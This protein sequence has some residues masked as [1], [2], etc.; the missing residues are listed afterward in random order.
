MAT[1][2][3]S[4]GWIPRWMDPH[5]NEGLFT[6]IYHYG[7]VYWNE[8]LK[9]SSVVPNFFGQTTEDR[10]CYSSDYIVNESIPIVTCISSGIELTVRR[11]NTWEA[12]LFEKIDKVF[13]T[14]GFRLFFRNLDL[15]TASVTADAS[16]YLN[17]PYDLDSD[18]AIILKDQYNDLIEVSQE[19]PYWD[20]RYLTSYPGDVYTA[21]FRTTPRINRLLSGEDYIKVGTETVKLAYYTL[22]NSWDRLASVNGIKRNTRETNKSI[23]SRIQNYILSSNELCRISAE[24]G[25]SI[26]FRWNTGSSFSFVG[27]GVTAI[28]LFDLPKKKYVD[29]QVINQQYITSSAD[30]LE[31]FSRGTVID[32]S[33]F[34]TASGIINISGYE[35]LDAKYIHNNYTFASSALTA[36]DLLQAVVFGTAATKVKFNSSSRTKFSWKWNRQL[37]GLS[38]LAEFDF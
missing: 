4:V 20:G 38:G 15:E 3:I 13:Y 5:Y 8:E 31:L 19:N 34:S 30:Y 32:P 6:K 7:L 21:Y 22:E 33:E 37:R 1:R 10:F 26:S 16:G 23:K 17:F 29:E 35:S 25:A 27:S 2:N 12:F 36:F 14:D 24:L 9:R 11:I 28:S 18:T